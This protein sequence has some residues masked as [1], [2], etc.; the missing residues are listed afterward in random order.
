MKKK[1]LLALCRVIIAVLVVT[2]LS[3]CVFV[4]LSDFGTMT[5][6]GAREIYEFKVGEY[7]GIKVEGYC[8]VRY[9]AAQ[10]DTVA[11]AVSPNVL[12]YYTIE[13]IND[14]LVVRTSK[15]INFSSKNSPVLTV[16]TPVLKRLSI[17]GA[18]T[19][20]TQDKIT[21]PS[22]AFILRGAGTARA[23]LDVDNLYSELSGAGE[24]ELSGRADTADLN[25]S[26]TGDL[27]ALSLQTREATVSLS[28]AGK[29]RVSCSDNLRINA[30]GMGEVV[31]RGS[32]KININKGGMV[33]ITQVK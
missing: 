31:Y 19:F 15:R 26:G 3:G 22:L 28:G 2:G 27:D 13:V 5:A 21:A 20:T 33:S 17:E 23:E 30:D 8:D 6:K 18:G 14:E 9:Y 11:L 4:S 12:E 16:S 24:L 32:P 1:L 25:L 7:T 10:S 29:I